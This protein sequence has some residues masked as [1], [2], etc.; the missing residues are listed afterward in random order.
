MGKFKKNYN[1][2]VNK[3]NLGHLEILEASE[4][5]QSRGRCL[6]VLNP[7]LVVEVAFLGMKPRM[8]KLLKK[9]PKHFSQ[10]MTKK[11][12]ENPQIAFEKKC[13][14]IKTSMEGYERHDVQVALEQTLEVIQCMKENLPM[15][16]VN[17]I[18]FENRGIY[19]STASI[20]MAQFS[21]YVAAVE[22]DPRLL[23]NSRLA[24]GSRALSKE[25]KKIRKDFRDVNIAFVQRDLKTMETSLEVLIS[26][27]RDYG[28][29]SMSTY[30]EKCLETDLANNVAN[31]INSG[32]PSYE[33]A[34][35]PPSYEEALTMIQEKKDKKWNFLNIF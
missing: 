13:E 22:S 28:S 4:F 7:S 6:D 32:P 20:L 27:L 12:R 3:M 26:D 33:Q 35:K 31:T 8:P 11:F 2:V 24:V 15:K 17:K 10:E 9:N 21:G 23:P 30:D 34:S 16:V 29:Q 19:M 25:A 5:Y 14:E 1:T 18:W